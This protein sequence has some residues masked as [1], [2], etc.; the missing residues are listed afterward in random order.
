MPLI[1]PRAS[2]TIIDSATARFLSRTNL[3]METLQPRDEA[4]LNHLL[5][6]QLPSAVEQSMQSVGSSLQQSMKD[7]IAA[8]PTV[9]PTLTAATQ[10]TLK[11]MERD[12]QN[13]HNK[14][15]N[16]TKRKDETL[17]RQFLRAQAQLFPHGDPQERAVGFVYFLNLYGPTFID[18]LINKLSLAPNQHSVLRP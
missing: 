14:I 17:R 4:A 3:P 13:L 9:D 10:S 11:R 1:Y 8:V 12:L 2:A 16:A 18:L 7:L 6:T 15:L 5:E